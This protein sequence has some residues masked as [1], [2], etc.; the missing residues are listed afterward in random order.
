[1]LDEKTGALLAAIN[2]KCGGESY[3][4]IE[5]KELLEVIPEGNGAAELRSLLSFLEAE[6]Y[7]EVSY[8]ED[9]VYCLRPLTEGRRYFEQERL[10]RHESRVL[11][12]DGLI[13]S[14]AGALFGAFLGSA[15]F[16]AVS[17]LL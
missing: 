16:W 17:L 15:L 8:A 1:M 7:V 6:R 4:I 2:E 14:A 11:R 3:Q 13:L 10:R 9:G 12:R 5:E